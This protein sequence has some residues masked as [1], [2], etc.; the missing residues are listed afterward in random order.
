MKTNTEL[1]TSTL[2]EMPDFQ[3]TQIAFSHLTNKEI[4]SS[5]WL[6]RLMNKPFLVKVGAPIGLWTVK[7]NFPFARMIVERT[8]FRQFVGGSSLLNTIPTIQKLAKLQTLTILD[9]GVEARESEEDLNRTLRENLR[10]IE[11]AADHPNVP[12]VST[13]ISGLAS[14][15]LLEKVQRGDALNDVEEENYRS[16]IKRVEAIAYTAFEKGVSVFFDAEESWIQDPIDHMVNA[17]MRRYNKER[18]V[19]Y[20]TYQMYRHDRLKFLMQNATEAAAEGWMLGAKIVRGAYMEKERERAKQKGYASP[21]YPDKQSTDDAYNKALRFLIENYE[22]IGSCNASHNA[23]SNQLMAQWIDELKINRNHPHLNFSQLYGMSDNITFNLAA[24]GYNVAKYV[25]YG[26]VEEV[27]PYLIRRAQEN[28]SVT[29][30]MS[31]ELELISKEQA[32]RKV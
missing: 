10:A 11:F 9:Y 7:W 21:I 2:P 23:E 1:L 31:R 3:D 4:S 16:V 14:N 17:M 8:I 27:I 29:G 19:I 5:S 26:R 30:E 13:K 32:R 15:A 20:N 22:R 24:S 28:T 18:V 25:P 12:V 6:F